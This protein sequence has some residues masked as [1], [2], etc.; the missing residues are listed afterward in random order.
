MPDQDNNTQSKYCWLDMPN[1][2]FSN[3]WYAEQQDRDIDEDM[4]KRARENGWILIKY[5]AL[6][7]PK[8]EFTKHMK[9][10]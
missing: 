4:M 5:E 2:T 3:S 10:R 6:N 7:D 8:F 1:G 9:L